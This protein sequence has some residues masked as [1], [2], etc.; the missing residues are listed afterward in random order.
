MESLPIN[1]SLALQAPAKINLYLRVTGK[2]PDGYHELETLF[3]RVTLADTLTFESHPTQVQLTCN[4]SEL[5]CGEDNL[6][7]KAARLLQQETGVQQGARI[8]LSKR[9]PIAAGL[10]G[11]SSDAAAALVGLNQIWS[12]NLQPQILIEFG[13]RLGSDVAFFLYSAPYAVGT[14]RGE[15][16]RPLASGIRLAHVL[17][18]PDARLATPEIFKGSSFDLTAAKP[19]IKM[20]EHA[21]INGS[22][23]ELASGLYNDLEPEAIRRCPIIATIQSTLKRLGCLAV[24][25][26]GSGPS[27]Y[28]L[29][30]GL[31]QASWIAQE[32]RKPATAPWLIDIIETF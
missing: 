27:V 22:L 5:S 2:R 30:S 6:V 10:G 9:I 12:L 8:H 19:S 32:L 7:M 24:R 14:G 31:E 13:A 16:C 20:L 1:A 17:V 29:C 25:M 3:E 11:G 23:S 26:S 21:L 4:N 28:G 15:I 18:V